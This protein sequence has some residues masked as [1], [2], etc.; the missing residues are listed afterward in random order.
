[1]IFCRLTTMGVFY[2][3]AAAAFFA[4]A[5]LAGPE[6]IFPDDRTMGNPKAP[7]TVVEYASPMCPYCALVAREVL[8]K[9]KKEYVDTGKVY[10]IFRVF[11]LGAP[12]GAVSSLAKCAARKSPKGYFDFIALAYRQQPIWDPDGYDIPDVKAG[13]IKLAGLAG[14]KPDEAERCMLDK[15]E[16]E[17]VNRI[18]TD[19]E[20]RYSI[21]GTPTFV[22]NGTVLPV[23]D[24]RWERL[25]GHIDAA[26]PKHR[27]RK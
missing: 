11:P 23:E 19:A 7:V 5:A 1:M 17:R 24:T 3:V 10:F 21:T 15:P 18:A 27:R 13:L 4:V 22:I 16:W 12:D 14:I 20:E 9:L 8:P 6:K 2:R 26:L 25:K